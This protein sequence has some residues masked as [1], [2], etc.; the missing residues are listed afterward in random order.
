VTV[1]PL[2]WGADIWSTAMCPL[3][4][5]T[6]V[7]PGCSVVVVVGGTVE[8]VVVEEEDVAGTVILGADVPE[9]Q[10]TSDDP[11]RAAATAR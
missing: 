6:G 3:T 1:S 8:V 5:L 2:G 10:P 7:H 11:S 9:V 4:V